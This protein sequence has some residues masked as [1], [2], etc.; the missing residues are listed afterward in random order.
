VESSGSK[1]LVFFGQPAYM[2]YVRFNHFRA[3]KIPVKRVFEAG[4][5]LFADS[6]PVAWG[7]P[8]TGRAP[9]P[10]NSPGVSE[11]ILNASF[12]GGEGE[13]R[14]QQ[15]NQNSISFWIALDDGASMM[16]SDHDLNGSLQR[17]DSASLPPSLNPM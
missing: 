7:R 4:H 15:S 16:C 5:E 9:S 14:G 17:S 13:G 1:S 10:I 2:F 3:V 11:A 12:K 8:N 6:G